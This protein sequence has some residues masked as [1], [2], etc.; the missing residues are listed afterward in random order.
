[1]SQHT[2][3][4]IN[5]TLQLWSQ[6]ETQ[7]TASENQLAECGHCHCDCKMY[8]MLSA[9]CVLSSLAF[10]A[11]IRSCFTNLYYRLLNCNFHSIS[12]QQCSEM[13]QRYCLGGNSDEN[14]QEGLTRHSLQENDGIRTV[15]ITD[16]QDE[17]TGGRICGDVEVARSPADH[18]RRRSPLLPPRNI[19]QAMPGFLS[20]KLL[21]QSAEHSEIVMVM[22]ETYPGH[23]DSQRAEL[24]EE[25]RFDGNVSTGTADNIYCSVDDVLDDQDNDRDK[26][27][28]QNL[29]I[30]SVA[31][32]QLFP[33]S[34]SLSYD[35]LHESMTCLD[36]LRDHSL[37]EKSDGIHD[38]DIYAR[39]AKIKRWT[40][41]NR[42]R[43]SRSCS[44]LVFDS[45]TES[46]CSTIFPADAERKRLGTV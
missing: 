32:V 16:D 36:H 43:E 27:T 10:L 28:S 39:P 12:Q 46:K 45:G 6:G 20:R 11:S 29:P 33:S 23:I 44:V 1:M 22:M 26:N 18:Q 35:S 5:A 38:H 40:A 15:Q 7:T 42:N 19:L 21:Q 9:I 30:S 25:R 31:S 13:F 37:D 2:S 17:A 3:Q 34:H 14:V 24:E 8:P 41:P 4:D